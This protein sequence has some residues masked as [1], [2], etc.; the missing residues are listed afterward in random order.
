MVLVTVRAQK[1]TAWLRLRN[2]HGQGEK[3]PLLDWTGCDK[4]TV[5]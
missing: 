1:K 4:I 2:N 5:K 3:K